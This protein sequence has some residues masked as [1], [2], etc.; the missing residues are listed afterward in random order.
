MEILRQQTS[1]FLLLFVIAGCQFFLFSLGLSNLSKDKS[2]LGQATR[3]PELRSP[4]VQKTLQPH[5]LCRIYRMAQRLCLVPSSTRP[6]FDWKSEGREE[7]NDNTFTL[8]E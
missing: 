7:G 4:V 3:N 8:R 5:D 2:L 6:I 1:F